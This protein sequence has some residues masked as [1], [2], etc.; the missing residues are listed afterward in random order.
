MLLLRLLQDRV[1]HRVD[2]QMQLQ[3]RGLRVLVLGLHGREARELVCVLRRL[4]RRLLCC[5]LLRDGVGGVHCVR[6][7][8][9][10]GAVLGLGH[11]EVWWCGR[12]GRVWDGAVSRRCCKAATEREQWEGMEL[13][14][15]CAK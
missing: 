9:L 6:G 2:L 3:Q 14:E 7:V 5:L 12:R 1:P 8:V 11:F 15:D 4:L 13:S 10:G